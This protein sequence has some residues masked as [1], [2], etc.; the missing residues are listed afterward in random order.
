ETGRSPDMAPM[1]G[2]TTSASPE[3]EMKAISGVGPEVVEEALNKEFMSDDEYESQVIALIRV[4]VQW[5]ESSDRREQS[6]L[7]RQLLGSYFSPWCT[8]PIICKDHGSTLQARL[9]NANYAKFAT[10][11]PSKEAVVHQDD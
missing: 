8:N 10:T 6:R 3:A 9:D 2:H 7:R 11:I 4:F 5:A 1:R